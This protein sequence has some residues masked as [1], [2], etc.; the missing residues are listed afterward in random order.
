MLKGNTKTAFNDANSIILTESIAKALFGNGDPMNKTIR[1]DNRNDVVVTGVMKDVPANSTL[2]F[3]YLLPYSLIEQT[4]PNAKKDR[5][6]WG[7]HS[8]IEY[9]E[10]QPG[11]DV[12]KFENK[13]KDL[14]AQH[15]PDA[16]EKI[17]VILQPEI[18]SG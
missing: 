2:Q 13:I 9:V 12:A 5:I 4:W 7:N 3:T 16:T 1:V 10:L 11:I 6:D 14:N 17:E 18:D 15:E 8:T